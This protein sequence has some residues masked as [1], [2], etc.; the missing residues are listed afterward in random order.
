MVTVTGTV[1][2]SHGAVTQQA[3]ARQAR[4]NL[5]GDRDGRAGRVS[6]ESLPHQFRDRDDRHGW[7]TME[8]Q[9]VPARPGP[10]PCQRDRHA[11][12]CGRTVAR[13]LGENIDIMV[14]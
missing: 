12:R 8:V 1:R 14:R 9:P 5:A 4:A 2:A 3:E 7:I 6:I 11:A 13:N 10:G